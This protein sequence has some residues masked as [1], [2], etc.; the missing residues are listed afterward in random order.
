ML[1]A[2]SF[3][4]LGFMVYPKT[5]IY[6][7]LAGHTPSCCGWEWIPLSTFISRSSIGNIVCDDRNQTLAY[8]IR[9][10]ASVCSCKLNRYEETGGKC[11][12][13]L[14]NYTSVGPICSSTGCPQ[15]YHPYQT[16]SNFSCYNHPFFELTLFETACQSENIIVI[17]LTVLI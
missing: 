15:G 2:I 14:L 12:L 7:F 11:Q 6:R 17:L 9:D 8:L 10:G 4:S 1:R 16:G 5:S 3:L 13:D